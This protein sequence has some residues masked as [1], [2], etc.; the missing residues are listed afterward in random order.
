MID[1]C[2]GGGGETALLEVDNDAGIFLIGLIFEIITE[3]ANIER[4]RREEF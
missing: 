1:D 4:D 2:C 3:A